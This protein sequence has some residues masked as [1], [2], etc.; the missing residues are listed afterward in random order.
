M[1][2]D[3]SQQLAAVQPRSASSSTT[4][5]TTRR[6]GSPHYVRPRPRPRGSGG[7]GSDVVPRHVLATNGADVERRLTTHRARPGYGGGGRAED[8]EMDNV[9]SSTDDSGY[10]ALD[11]RRRC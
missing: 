1:T 4:T 7:S 2:R 8:E 6:R 5:T 10:T 11:L 3:T 9:D